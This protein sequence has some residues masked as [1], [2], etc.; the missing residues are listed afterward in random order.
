MMYNPVF[1]WKKQ[2]MSKSIALSTWA[3]GVYFLVKAYYLEKFAVDQAHKKYAAHKNK[4]PVAI[5]G[6]GS[7]LEMSLGALACCFPKK[8]MLTKSCCLLA[9]SNVFSGFVLTRGVFGIKHLT[10]PGFALFG[11]LRLIEIWR[12]L[13]YEITNYPQAWLLLQVGTVVRLL[14]Y[15]VLPYTSTDGVRGDLFTEPTIY[16][17]NILLSG[18]VTAAFVYPPKW[19]IS[20]L[21]IYALWQNYQPPRISMKRRPALLDESQAAAPIANAAENPITKET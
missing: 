8:T 13:G 1:D 12:T 14:G 11:V 21:F 4:L 10:V 6:I 20:Q 2:P 18:T 3:V 9:L 19:V 15:F 17:F 16:S 7:S 5:H